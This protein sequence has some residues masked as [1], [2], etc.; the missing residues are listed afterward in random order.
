MKKLLAVALIALMALT[1]VFANGA[2]E[3]APAEKT[4][5]LTVWAWDP[6]FNIPALLEAE[7]IYQE[8]HPDFKLNIV[9]NPSKDIEVKFV[10]A[11]Q[12]GDYSTLPDIFLMQDNSYQKFIANYPG[13]FTTLD[14]SGINFAD[15]AAGK[16]A[17]STANGK[18]YGVPFDNGAV[19][20]PI[21][22]DIIAKAGLTVAD[23]NGVTWS[24]FF[25]N[26][27]KVKKATGI[28]MLTTSGGSEIV[29]MILQSAGAS[30]YVNG[31]V[32]IENNAVLEE[33][34]KIYA[35]LIKEGLMTDYTD[36]DQYIAS[37][38]T[39][40][41]AGLIQ[42]NWIISSITAAAD[43]SGKWAVVPLPKLEGVA[44]ATNFS[45]SGGAS[46]AVSS[47]CKNKELAF[48]FLK[49]TLGS[50]TALYDTLLVNNGVITT[51][52]PAA[53]SSKYQDPVEF[54]GGQKVYSDIV[55]YANGVPTYDF[56]SYYND[57]RS[58]ITDAI[59]NVVQK[60]A[61]VKA[62]MKKAQEAVEF[63]IG[64]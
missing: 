21:R 44:G 62:E 57:I 30:P 26:A 27:T 47:A 64:G 52:L 20:M 10:T 6:N 17:M 53:K 49:T 45:N 43:Q 55:S 41:A 54:F 38:N 14:D 3:S 50:N 9:E 11:D 15:F 40:K 23:F 34:I 59:T 5:T 25:E 24:Q 35:R 1:A 61:D 2:K 16:S 29:L 13:I 46:W 39:G 4:N 48:D 31:K 33:A 51:Y 18:H 58:A 8:T 28:D 36:W 12:A 60:G 63:A 19:I 56:G 37:F 22:T 42:G 7:K 32:N